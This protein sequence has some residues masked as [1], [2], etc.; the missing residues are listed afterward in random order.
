MTKFRVDSDWLVIALIL[1]AS[2]AGVVF[3]LA[4]ASEL[5]A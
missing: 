2:A 5:M 3:F 4:T 1:S